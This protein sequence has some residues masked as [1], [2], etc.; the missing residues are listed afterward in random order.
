MPNTTLPFDAQMYPAKHK[1]FEE[2][3]FFVHFYLGSK[4]LIKRHIEFVNELG[5]DAFA[6][7]LLDT[8]EF[9]TNPMSKKKHLGIKH[10]WA[11]QIESL[12]NSIPQKKI[13]FSFSNPSASAIEAMSYRSCL[14]I[15]GL[16][17]DSGPSG[18]FLISAYNLFRYYKE[19]GM[20]ES[21]VKALA[22]PLF[23]SQ[24][25]H[26][27]ITKH[28]NTFPKGFPILSIRGWKDTLI[29]P[30]HI[31]SVFEGHPQLSWRK[32]SL[33]K[34]GHLNGL[35]DFKEM[36]TQGLKAFLFEI[37]TKIPSTPNI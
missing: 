34:A 9:L 25:L 17:C 15:K 21:V 36:Y 2:V 35:K 7:N 29:P 18:K 4:T 24:Y 31:D 26:N 30:D 28:L 10:I 3:V 14:D 6:F 1:K 20:L 33:P 12:L 11:D 27:D 37:G 5:F 13:I 23:W 19:K 32:L 22:T 16:I 8:K